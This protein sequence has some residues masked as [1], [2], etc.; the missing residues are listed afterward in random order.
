M[1]GAP[2]AKLKPDKFMSNLTRAIKIAEDFEEDE[3][4]ELIEVTWAQGKPWEYW[5]RR[6]N[7]TKPWLQQFLVTLCD[8][9]GSEKWSANAD[10]DSYTG[11][12]GRSFK[13]LYPGAVNVSLREVVTLSERP[14]SEVSQVFLHHPGEDSEPYY[15]LV[16]GRGY[17]R[18]GAT[19]GKHVMDECP[20]WQNNL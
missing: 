7:P 12:L 9:D 2:S 17:F 15:E 8:S 16:Y 6:T 1:G 14:A 18:C 4:F 13:P 20:R 10:P 11:N 19:S 5:F 3:A